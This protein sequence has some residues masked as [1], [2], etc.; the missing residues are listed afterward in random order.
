MGIYQLNTDKLTLQGFLLFIF[1]GRLIITPINK[2]SV[3]FVWMHALIASYGRISELFAISNEVKDGPYEINSLKNNVAFRNVSFSYGF[4][5]V[6]TDISLTLKKGETI[7]IVGQSGS[8]KSTITDLFLRLYDPDKG[9]IL[10]DNVNLKKINGDKYRNLFGVVSQESLLFNDTIENNI[11]FGRSN[12]SIQEIELAARDANAHEFIENLPEGYQTFVGDRGIK[13]SGGERQRIS[14]ARAICSKPQILIFDEATSSLDSRS[15]KKV[16]SSIK[17]LL[18]GS[19]GIII[20]HRFSTILDADRILVVSDGKIE[21]EGIHNDLLSSSST[22]KNLY[23][24]QS[25]KK[26]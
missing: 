26:E 6:L 14:I 9:Q 2:F 21:A 20:A 1:V 8:G 22:Y 13:L 5:P 4:S 17:S 3:N 25:S 11:R 15:E 19:T 12:L 18:E 23:N 7:A 10:I 24:L 16:Q